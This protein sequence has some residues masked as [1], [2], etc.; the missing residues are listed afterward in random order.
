MRKTYKPML[1][2]LAE[3]PFSSEDWIFEI[4]WG[5]I[6]A[7]VY[8]YPELSVK[9]AEQRELRS[10]F[11]ELLELERSEL[12]VVLDGEIVILKNHKVDLEALK[13]RIHTPSE[14]VNRVAERT[15]S[16]YIAFDILEKN[17]KP[18]L[19]KPL[20]VRKE[21]LQ[22]VIGRLTQVVSSKYADQNGEAYFKA[23]VREGF[24]AI[25]AKKKN[26]RYEPG[27]RSSSWLEI[28]RKIVPD[29]SVQIKPSAL[30]EYYEKRDFKK[31][32]EPI[33]HLA[34]ARNIF[35]VQEH[36]SRKLHYDLRLARE[37]VLKSWAVPKGI[38]ELPGVKRLAIRTED[39][40]LEYSNF[41]G[42]IPEGEYG[43][44]TVRIWDKGS[45]Y[46]KI[47]SEDKIEFS[48]KGSRL[49]GKY[50]LVKFKK[51]GSKEWLLLKMKE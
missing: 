49:S 32:S 9:D 12:D 16:T 44:G 25:L 2:H 20:G 36:H 4:E 27:S 29:Q 24:E 47:W 31:T 51:A 22:K 10:K 46:T 38:P 37:G 45:Y 30:K 48:V 26:S 13:R 7:I 50:V 41:E 23:A 11:P 19:D 8:T 39:H 17:G 33:G 5:G 43:A 34:N 1:P 6:R 21:I 42:S 15:P 14:E 18:L 35:V 40:P 28:K 3:T